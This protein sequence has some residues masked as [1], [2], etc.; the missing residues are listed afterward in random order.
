MKA[1]Q[2]A[3]FYGWTNLGALFFCYLG[4]GL[5]FYG[6][7]VIFPA[8]VKAM[9]WARGDA[10]IAQ[11][12]RILVVGF[13]SPLIAIAINRWGVKRTILCSGAM[14]I[15]GLILLGTVVDQIWQ[16]ILLWGVVMGIGMAGSGLI[17]VQT[18]ITYW[19]S[20]NRGL[21]LGVVGC[22]A[23]L[24]GFAAQPFFTWTM[25]V[26]GQWQIAWI[27]AAVCV[28]LSIVGIFWL[29]NKPADYAQY[30][31]GISP[32]K[33]K[34]A[35]ASGRSKAARTY[36]TSVG[37]TLEEARKHHT[38]WL[39]LMT[40]GILGMPM[41][42]ITSHGVLHMLDSNSFTKMQAAYIISLIVLG[43]GISRFPIGWL[44][45]YFEARW[46][47]VITMTG[48]MVCTV[49][50]WQL[51]GLTALSVAAFIFG[52]CHGSNCILL[53]LLIGNYYGPQPFASINGF[54]FPFTTVMGALVPVVA[55]YIHDS[56]KSY[57]WAFI[58]LI[59][60]AVIAII[61]AALAAPPSKKTAA[62]SASLEGL[63]EKQEATP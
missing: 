43:G 38:M 20:R 55:G 32:E 2:K 28:F 26:S 31:D 25:K 24:G 11:T 23:A 58:G 63:A 1:G 29:R 6:F 40:Y 49:I 50:F 17:S 52:L 48:Y 42:F 61:C 41:Y 36:R 54:M 8:M 62:A 12:V 56:T 10:S 46:L 19:F 18:N 35:E 22:G 60:F 14:S 37:W 4:F 3:R 47:C 39:L 51:P 15:A 30:P 57:Q 33:T 45:D 44:A 27:C 5:L 13:T 53:P 34:E 7:S 59:V 16:W 9:N 21:A